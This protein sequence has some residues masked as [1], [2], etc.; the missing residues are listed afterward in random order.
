MKT[1]NKLHPVFPYLLNCIDFEGSNVEKIQSVLIAFNS[2]YNHDYNKKYYPNLQKRFSEWLQGLPSCINVDFQNYKIL[3]IAKTWESL[4]INAT[5]RQ[6][7]KILSNWFNFISV[8]F[9]QLCKQNKVDYSYV[10]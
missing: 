5:E 9:F 2:E 10:Y 6:E 1:N 7:D 4:P 8:K 3:E